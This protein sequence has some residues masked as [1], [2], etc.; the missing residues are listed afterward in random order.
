VSQVAASATYQWACAAVRLGACAGIAAALLATQPSGAFEWD[1]TPAVTVGAAQDTNIRLTAT[2]ERQVGAAALTAEMGVVGREEGFEFRFAP[3]LTSLRYDDDR[4][5]DRDNRYADFSIATHDDRQRWSFG[6]GYAREGTLTTEFESTGFVETDV[7]RNQ[8]S[9][10]TSWTR[11]GEHGAY[12][13]A[14]SSSATDYEQALFSPLVDY[15]YRVLQ[16]GYTR[17]TNERSNWRYGA[18]RMQLSAESTG[19]Q[20]VSS[21]VRATWSR[22]FSE[23]LQAR[24]GIGMFEVSAEGPLGSDSSGVSLDFNVDRLWPR[25]RF[26]TGGGRELQPDGRGA[27][28]RVDSARL[29]MLRRITE[30]F[31]L[32]ANLAAAQVRSE[33]NIADLYDRDYS[34][35]GLTLQWRF[36]RLWLLEGAFFE[37]AHEAP[38]LPQVTG[39]VS[40]LSVSYRGL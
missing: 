37:R 34:Q 40:Q 22:A 10:Y 35:G 8:S 11:A 7:D 4:E 21:D 25:W 28:V 2:D 12:D 20:T 17:T 19:F 30:R 24:L 18:S 15:K 33:G 26:T 6:G 3:R 36:R 5:F 27:L 39:I 9:L 16:F 13:L 29:T 1:Y 32:G 31:S 23:A 38:L 14:L